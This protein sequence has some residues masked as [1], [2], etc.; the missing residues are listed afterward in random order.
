MNLK[1]KVPKVEPV[2]TKQNPLLASDDA[3]FTKIFEVH[4]GTARKGVLKSFKVFK[5]LEYEMPHENE[6]IEEFKTR[7]PELKL[8]CRSC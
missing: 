5:T 2:D 8:R 3:A 6:S 4:G 7:I 1:R